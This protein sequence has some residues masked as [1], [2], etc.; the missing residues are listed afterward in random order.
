MVSLKLQARLA[1]DILGCGRDRVWL[2]PN[3]AQDISQANS[4]KSVR[5]LIKDGYILRKPVKVHTRSR[6]RRME[7]AKGMGRHEGRGKRHG[8]REARLPSKEIWM[9]RLRI[10]RRML[11]KYRADKKIDARLYRELYL[12]AKGNVFKNKRN[13]MEHIHV[14]KDE[15]K[16]S[17]QLQEELQA[18]EQKDS[19]NREK[20]RK[21]EIKK[22][23][24]ERDKAKKA[25]KEAE[26]KA[27]D[28][29]RKAAAT[30]AAPKAAAKPAGKA[31]APVASPT[32]ATKS[33]ATKTAAA[34]PKTAAA[35][36]KAP[37]PAPKG[38]KQ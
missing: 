27:K 25:M 11:R 33:P 22:R 3:E 5:K 34:A 30:K 21:K 38:K 1:K 7:E 6:W 28:A 24:K 9:R 36:P 17:K 31:A 12:K 37:A 15:K 8:T 18:K 35:A 23:E 14:M 13:L 32:T 2:D 16:K 10:L 20:A 4:R 19:L 26:E 29:A